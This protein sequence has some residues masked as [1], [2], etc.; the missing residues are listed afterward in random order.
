M[1]Q[2]GG[3]CG[4][5]CPCW[6]VVLF[7]AEMQAC[8]K[9]GKADDSILLGDLPERKWMTQVMNYLH[10]YTE[11]RLFP[12]ISLAQYERILHNTRGLLEYS[13][14]VVLPHIVRHSSASNDACHRRRDLRTIQ[15]RGRWAAKSSVNRYEK[16]VLLQ[17]AWKFVPARRKSQVEK[18]KQRLVSVINTRL[19]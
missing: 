1:G 11:H 17:R 18:A 3:T 12:S 4:R 10:K 15:K 6:A 19:K 8:S 16:H 7:P 2:C 13:S 9:P 14:P 5:R